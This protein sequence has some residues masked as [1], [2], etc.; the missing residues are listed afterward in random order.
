MEFDETQ[1]GPIRFGPF[2]LRPRSDE[3]YRD[4]AP[5][6]L[7]P[8]P[9]KVLLFLVRNSGRLVTRKELQE[10]IWGTETFVDFDKGLNLCI[11]QI[12]EALGDDAQSPTY[13]ET[14]PRR[15]YRF[16]GKIE[17]VAGEDAAPEKAAASA[18]I[19]AGRKRINR[20]VAWLGGLAVLILIAA[21]AAGALYFR[22]PLIF[23]KAQKDTKSMLLVLPFENLTNDPAQDYFSDG[24]TEEMITRL[25]S[26]QPRRLGVIARTTALTYKK[27]G[28][29][30][31]QIGDEL[32][33]N[34][35][36]E[37]SV[38]R[39]GGRLRITSQLIQVGDQTHLWAE[40]FDRDE[41]DVLDIQREVA[42]R[43][44]SSLSLEL[45]PSYSSE[46]ASGK[47]AKPEAFDA[48]LKGRYLVTKDNPDD[49]KRSIP[50]FDQ[51][52]SEDPN[53]APAYAAQVEALVLLIDWTGA[54]ANSDLPKAKAAA[55]KAV[56][57]D[58]AY[59]EGYA[60]LG[61]VQLRLEWNSR[62]AEGN[63]RRAVELNPNNPLTRLNYGRC[64]LSRGQIEPGFREIEEALKLDPVSLLTT[65]IAAYTYLNAGRYDRAIE[66]SRRMLELEPKSPAARGCLFRAYVD[67]GDYAAAVT[68]TREQMNLWG[69]KPEEIKR[70]DAGAPKDVIDAR[71]RSALSEMNRSAERGEQV[72]TMYAAWVSVRLGENDQALQWLEKAADER[73]SFM[74][75][76][77]IDPVWDSLRSDPRF[78]RL[79]ERTAIRN[80]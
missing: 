6:K 59:A 60:A 63:F 73:A 77:G 15:G 32:G 68:I 40:T 44:A 31:K 9:Y 24:L 13:I 48:Y 35:V 76:L 42:A 4:E 58:P 78:D 30:I 19:P 80:S 41:K 67:K 62:D 79:I 36:L 57:L 75:Y 1:D 21:A 22:S 5:V 25:G 10:N 8:Q 52:I 14:L 23:T 18:G 17:T 2:E 7:P 20:T 74:L 66:L 12:R 16:I 28:K 34:Y 54:T 29:D 55:L 69:A 71:F 27:T 56:E 70:L 3:L 61:S 53:F 49:L 39:E 51:A 37:G 65:G 43:I 47:F 33:V 46:A 64:L 11:A 45:L 38:R 72:W 50:Y 26:L